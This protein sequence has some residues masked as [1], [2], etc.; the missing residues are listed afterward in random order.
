M[1]EMN[2]GAKSQSWADLWAVFRIPQSQTCNRKNMIWQFQ[3]IA[4]RLRVISKS[5]DRAASQPRRLY[6]NHKTSQSDPRID[7]CIEE[8]I[9]MVVDEVQ[10]LNLV[11]LPL[12]PVVGTKDQQA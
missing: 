4:H 6:R 3:K 5:A 12:A 2:A 10:P 7:A 1:I 8:R 9:K 11:Y